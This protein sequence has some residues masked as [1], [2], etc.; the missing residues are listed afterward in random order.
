[1]H[2]GIFYLAPCF[3]GCGLQVWIRE[4]R[5]DKGALAMRPSQKARPF[6]FLNY[7]YKREDA[8][9]RHNHSP[10]HRPQARTKPVRD[11]FG[12]LECIDDAAVL[13]VVTILLGVLRSAT[14]LVMGTI[15]RHGEERRTS[16]ADCI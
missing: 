13:V 11:I 14:L 7:Y 5:E 8:T 15:D 2:I 4:K 16:S 10:H 3:A 12:S 9:K 6:S 1:M